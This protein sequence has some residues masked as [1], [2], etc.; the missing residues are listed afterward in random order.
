MNGLVLIKIFSN[1]EDPRNTTTKNFFY[2]L[3][4]I[5]LVA[6]ATLLCGGSTYKDMKVFGE[7]KLDFFKT[8]LDFKNG[9]PSEDTFEEVF[10]LLN[11]KQFEQCLREWIDYLQLNY[12]DEIISIDGKT[13][14]RSGSKSAKPIHMVNAWANNNRV[15]LCCKAVSEKSNEITAIP[16]ILNMLSLAGT[17]VTTDA[18]GCQYEIGDQI[19]EQGGDYVLALKGN[20]GTLLEDV[21]TFFELEAADKKKNTDIKLHETLEK[22]HGRIEK[23]KYGFYSNV[24]WLRILHPRWKTMHGI[25]YVESTRIIDEKTT[26]EIRYF[27][28]SK[29][30][31]AIRFGEIVRAHWGV[32]NNLHNFLDVS[33]VEDYSRVRS[34]N[35]AINL[36]IVRRIVINKIEKNKEPKLSKRSMILKAGWDNE[37]LKTL[38][39]QSI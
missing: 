15:V 20:Q 12:K 14:R 1:M 23:R 18:M 32:E 37:Y 17:V 35:A 13:A 27:I 39:V 25:G 30:F 34:R 11:P 24:E 38:L 7:A 29:D 19:V 3:G 26:K 36:A 8:L 6:L 31:G 2:P 5:L 33:L 9:I 16:E 22:D 4:E 10:G 28:V 21:E